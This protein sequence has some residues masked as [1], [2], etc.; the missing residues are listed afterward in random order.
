MTIAVEVANEQDRL[1]IDAASLADAAQ[2]V[3]AG[4]GIASGTISLAVVDDPTMHELNRRYLEHDYPTDVLS[5]VLEKKTREVDGT[6]GPSYEL[7]GEVILS[8]DTAIATAAR[9]GWSASEELLLYVVHGCLHLAGY[10]DHTDNDRA[11]MRER[12]RLYLAEM[13]IEARYVESDLT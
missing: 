10:D 5:F 1:P 3:L 7:Q 8:A 12:E 9:F 13:G 6:G 2:R 4:E 11:K